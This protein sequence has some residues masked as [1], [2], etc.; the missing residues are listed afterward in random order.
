MVYH[1]FKSTDERDQLQPHPHV[2]PR[3]DATRPPSSARRRYI[4]SAGQ[5]DAVWLLLL[6]IVAF[7]GLALLS[8]PRRNSAARVLQ[9]EQDP[10]FEGLAYSLKGKKVVM[11]GDSLMRYKFITLVS[12]IDSGVKLSTLPNG[13]STEPGS[14][15]PVDHRTWKSWLEFNTG[16]LPSASCDCWHGEG[17]DIHQNIYTDISENR[18]YLKDG[19]D[20][21]FHQYF[22][23]A[24]SCTM[25]GWVGEGNHSLDT[26]PYD[27]CNTFTGFM[28]YQ[29]QYVHPD[30]VLLNTGAWQQYYR[31][32]VD[33]E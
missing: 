33:A 28:D 12:F 26:Q 23:G 20:I 2:S 14:R 11:I 9:P 7:S 32:A 22:M 24:G 1:S 13:N 3:T 5:R 30:V 25:A 31:K 15:N 16:S 17:D 29:V 18:H 6:G 10:S 27:W 19:F 21:S 4:P 8:S